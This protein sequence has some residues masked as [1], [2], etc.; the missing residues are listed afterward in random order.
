MSETPATSA[1]SKD[2][3]FPAF[4]TENRLLSLPG[5]EKETRHIVVSIAGSGLHYKSG[6]S[7]GVFPTNR[8]SE[9]DAILGHLGADGSEKVTLQRTPEPVSLREALTSRL[10]LAGPT[11][12]IVEILA[13]KATDP[14]EKSKLDGLLVPESKDLLAGWLHEREFV[15]LLAEFPS[16][17][18]APQ[19]L[20]EHMRKLMPRLYS[21]AS[22]PVV[23]PSEVHMTVAVVRY[24]TNGR[25]RVG[26][27]TTFMADRAA[28][29]TTPAPVFISH[30]HFGL[31]DDAGRDVIMVGP[32]TGIAPFRAFVQERAAKGS[33]GRNWLFFGDQRRGTD[34]LYEEDWAAWKGKGTLTRLDTAFSRD[35]LTKVYVQDRMRENAPALWEWIKGGAH[36]Y[37]CG[38]AKRMAKDVDT[39]LHD[40]IAEQSGKP[41]VEVAEYV[42]IMKKEKRY[43]RDVY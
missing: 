39:A 37:V 35:Q 25:D 31:P 4:V 5:S 33:P 28:V 15:D 12:R 24:T 19:E 16:A 3:P 2:N 20:V 14:A 23:H 30:S 9:V 43:Q 36:F 13:G 41:P 38:D 21:I 32:G 34:F 42:K 26:V 6:D 17:R 22:S 18:P 27:C 7:I 8:P 29:G 11:R 10:A 40:I 1:Y